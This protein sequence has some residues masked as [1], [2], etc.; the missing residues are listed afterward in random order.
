MYTLECTATLTAPVSALWR[1][2]S[3]IDRFPEWDP[4]EEHSHLDGPFEVGVTGYSKARRLPGGPFTIIAVKDGSS[5]TARGPLPGGELLI[6]YRLSPQEDG[7]VLARVRYQARGPSSP[8]FRFALAPR[9][10]REWPR[11]FVALEARARQ[12]DADR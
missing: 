2:W 12:L 1:V 9:L 6:E 3:D 10:R 11:V 5:W 8:I 7:Q 4:L